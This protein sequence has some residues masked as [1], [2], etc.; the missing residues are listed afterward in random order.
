M[1]KC[2]KTWKMWEK[3]GKTWK[4]VVFREKKVVFR[5]S[6]WKIMVIGGIS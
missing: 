6:F 2:G 5:G 4:N 3:R 1:G